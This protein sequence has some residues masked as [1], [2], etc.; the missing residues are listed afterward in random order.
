M[1]PWY[2]REREVGRDEKE[3]NRER[4]I[5]IYAVEMKICPKIALI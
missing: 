1:A 3:P 5:Y 4:N 2:N